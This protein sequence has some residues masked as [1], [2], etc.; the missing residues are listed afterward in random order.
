MRIILALF[1]YIYAF[2]IDV[3]KEKEI[4]M[5]IYINKYTNAYENKNLGYSEEKIYK[6]AVD[7]CSVK[8]D[9]EACLYIYNNFII[10]GNYKVEKNIFNLITILTHLGIIIQSDKDKKYKEIDYLIFLD[11]YKNA[12][13]EINYVLSK[14]NDTKT[15]EGL[16]LLKKMSDFEINRA[17]AC[18]LYH[19][20]KLQSDKI[21]MPCACKKNTALLIKPDTI[22]RA[23]LNLKLL[24]DKYKDSVSC[25]VVGGLY[26][27]GKGVR[28]N[29]KQA[30]KYYGLACDGGYQL[31]CDGYKRL[32]GY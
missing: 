8:K 30:K 22:K 21:D 13:D 25:G 19:N 4:E 24:C 1:I 26:E 29:F 31:G 17:Y 20:D 12:L 6:K 18:P 32:M 11:S 23:F 9:K 15:I 14:T 28:I 27:N 2:G 5:S 16:K 3:C 10:N 7:D